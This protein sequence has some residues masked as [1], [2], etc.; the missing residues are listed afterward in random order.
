[1]TG[2][3]FTGLVFAGCHR[4]DPTLNWSQGGAEFM[5]GGVAGRWVPRVLL[6]SIL[7]A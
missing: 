3:V 7:V 2:L 1:M 5:K 4:V 6:R